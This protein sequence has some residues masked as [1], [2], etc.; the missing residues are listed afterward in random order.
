MKKYGIW[1]IV[2]LCAL[3]GCASLPP[4]EKCATLKQAADAA[5]ANGESQLCTAAALAYTA[6]GCGVYE[7]VLPQ[8]QCTAEQTCNCYSKKDFVTCPPKNCS[9]LTCP[10]AGSPEKTACAETQDGPTCY[11]PITPSCPVCQTG[12]SCTD[13]LVGC[14]A[15]PVCP[16]CPTG[17]SCNDPKEGC[18]KNPISEDPPLIPDYEMIGTTGGTTTR[19]EQLW[20]A[21]EQWMSENPTKV[22]H[23][24]TN[25]GPGLSFSLKDSTVAC[26]WC[27]AIETTYAE[28]ARILWA[29]QI[30]SGQPVTADGG[31]IDKYAIQDAFDPQLFPYFNL[32]EY[33][34]ACFGTAQSLDGVWIRQ[35]TTPPQQT[36]STPLPNRD[37]SWWWLRCENRHGCSDSDPGCVIDCTHWTKPGAAAQPPLLSA[38]DYAKAIGMGE[39][40]GT[41][42][43]GVPMRNECPP[44][45][46]DSCFAPNCVKCWERQACEVYV[47]EG[48]LHVV[49]L[50]GLPCTQVAP[51]MFLAR[52]GQCK[53]CNPAETVCSQPK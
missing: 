34:G 45:G 13:P 19:W 2:A 36:C 15:N 50:D 38:C 28:I 22:R 3:C 40:D 12:Y 46:P 42:R 52:N 1:N 23:T 21:V 31:R 53:L 20:P 11:A 35:V 25:G 44:G 47:A 24:C 37:S 26:P 18:V 30:W 39:M 5:C 6:A 10:P 33:G 4:A 41:P 43:C 32:L 7:P 29:Q 27:K 48:P 16:T 17:Y 8:P 49:S 9:E 51:T 14:V